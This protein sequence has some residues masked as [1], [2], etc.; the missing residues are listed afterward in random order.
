MMHFPCTQYVFCFS[1]C[2]LHGGG[3]SLFVF[4]GIDHLTMEIELDEDMVQ[5][6][7]CEPTTNDFNSMIGHIEDIVIS[8][9]FQVNIFMSVTLNNYNREIRT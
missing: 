9:S 4:M 1:K 6:D 3:F 2:F 8:D 7:G 5:T